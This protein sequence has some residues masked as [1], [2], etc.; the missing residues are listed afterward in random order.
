[1]TPCLPIRYKPCERGITHPASSVL[2][3]GCPLWCRAQ[4][5]DP[6]LCWGLEADSLSPS[7][8]LTLPV[9]SPSSASF[10]LAEISGD[11][12]FVSMPLCFSLYLNES[13]RCAWHTVNLS[14]KRCCKARAE[15]T[16][17]IPYRNWRSGVTFWENDVFALCLSDQ[18]SISLSC[19]KYE[20][21]TNSL[22]QQK[23]WKND[24]PWAY[25]LL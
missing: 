14:S 4:T 11:C 22:A 3:T 21:T 20:R 23:D 17:V 24:P 15:Y 16:H 5:F 1:M 2:V 19:D 8:A 25:Q 18:R 6:P 10:F 13:S 12:S 7:L 9:F